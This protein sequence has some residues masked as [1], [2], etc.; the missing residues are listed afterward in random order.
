MR[1]PRC[2]LVASTVVHL[3]FGQQAPAAPTVTEGKATLSA[4]AEEVV[5]DLIVRDKKGRPVRD[6]KAEEIEIVD[7]DQPAKIRSLRFTELEQTSQDAKKLDP[8]R[9]IRLVTLLFDSLSVE[10]AI[11]ARA[12]AHELVKAGAGPNV[13]FSIFRMAGRLRPLQEFTND[14]PALH[15]AIDQ[16]GGAKA[17]FQFHSNQIEK[18]LEMLA[19]GT[20][21]AATDS[22]GKPLDPAGYVMLGSCLTLCRP[23]NKMA[24]RSRAAL[25]SV[26]FGPPPTNNADC[27]A[28]RQS[29][30]SPRAG[31]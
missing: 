1:I 13:Y 6:L 17:D 3:A 28:A 23:R 18:H 22:Y 31:I 4:T 16:F 8:M 2:L 12:A 14:G 29:S 26:R 9:Q 10:P 11:Q 15:K 27:R 5:L 7:G 21:V 20:S 30:I 25:S 24:R 19:A